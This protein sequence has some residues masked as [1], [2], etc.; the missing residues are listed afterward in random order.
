[1]NQMLDDFERYLKMQRAWRKLRLLLYWFRYVNEKRREKLER[2][3]RFSHQQ[4]SA[5]RL[6][7]SILQTDSWGSW[8]KSVRR[9]YTLWFHVNYRML[10]L[11]YIICCLTPLFTFLIR[12]VLSLCSQPIKDIS[13]SLCLWNGGV[14]GS[15]NHLVL[16]RDP[17]YIHAIYLISFYSRGFSWS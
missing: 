7:T 8:M 16:A 15:Q 1:M 17:Y 12:I 10:T 13:I 3:L 5:R 2:Q 14:F 4:H 6:K 9:N 11:V